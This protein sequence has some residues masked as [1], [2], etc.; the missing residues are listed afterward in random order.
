MVFFL[1]MQLALAVSVALL[2]GRFLWQWFRQIPLRNIPGPPSPSFFI[3]NM[4]QLWDPLKG[5][6]F[7]DEIVKNY[8]RVVRLT[9]VFGDTMLYVSDPRALYHVLLKDRHHFEET[10]AF[11][12]STSWIFGQGLLSSSGDIH[13]R[14]RKLLNPVFSGNSMRCLVPI[15]QRVT[16]DLRDLLAKKVEEEKT[17]LDMTMWMTRLSLELIGQGGLGYTFDALNECSTNSYGEAVKNLAPMLSKVAIFFQTVP[18]LDKI[19]PRSFRRFVCDNLFSWWPTFNKLA[20]IVD[21]MD[22]TTREVF[23]H[24][25]AALAQGDDALLHQIGEGRDIM[26]VLLKVSLAASE[27]DRMSDIELLGQMNAL[28]FAGMDTTTSALSRIFQALAEHPDAQDK[29]RAEL[30][31]VQIG[32]QDLTY[33]E[34]NDLPYLDAITRETLR[35]YPP[36]SFIFR[37][38]SADAVL[39]L[40]SP[41]LG[42]DGSKMSELHIAK[43]TDIII[44]ILAVNRDPSI[45]GP[46]ASEWKPERWLSPLS[47][48]GP[49]KAGIPGVYSNTGF[50]F[51]LLEIKVVLSM[52]VPRLRFAPAQKEIEWLLGPIASPS[53][54]GCAGS[55]LPL[56][57]S[58][59]K[60]E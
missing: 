12:V 45:W 42:L 19:G 40:T 37:S 57:V 16:K 47:A 3:G 52:L 56:E 24:K 32:G 46:D 33:D 10:D 30:L 27:Q 11:M 9:G 44:S 58:L 49:S 48:S 28:T 41:M 60:D 18:W 51:A 50:K 15:F 53:V 35:L 14:H 7:H 38:T 6:K 34:L 59:V 54:K 17:E 23:E 5:W 31:E 1:W 39:P 4:A 20:R 36:F 26:S 29:L 21:V 8:G 25:K 55:M 2:A 43:D 13:R 22:E